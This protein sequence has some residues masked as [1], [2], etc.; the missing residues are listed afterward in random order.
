[1]RQ[2]VQDEDTVNETGQTL[3][4]RRGIKTRREIGE[5]DNGLTG[6]MRA[7]VFLYQI[8]MLKDREQA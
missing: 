5:T 6:Q 4:T 1:M 2:K 3:K 8:K 7:A